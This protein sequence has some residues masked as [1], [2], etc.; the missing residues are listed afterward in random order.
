MEKEVGPNWVPLMGRFE[1]DGD[2]LVFK[3]EPIDAP[4]SG[5]EKPMVGLCLS[6]QTFGE[7]RISSEIEFRST[8]S[9][10]V[11]EIVFFYDPSTRN[12]LT[13]GLSSLAA[14]MFGIRHWNSQIWTQIAVSGESS[15]LKSGQSY[16]IQLDTKGSRASLTVDGVEVLTATLP[17]PPPESQVGVFCL[18]ASETRIRRFE[19]QRQKPR[20]FV[21]MQFTPQYDELYSEVIKPVCDDLGIVPQRADETSTP[22]I[23]VADIA[24]QII[25]SK[26][27]IAE[28]SPAN[29]NVYY[30]V[31]FSHALNKPTILIADKGTRPPFDVAPF[32][33]LFY[34]NSIGGKKKVEDGLRQYLKSI[35]TTRTAGQRLVA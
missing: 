12:M 19:I 31:G 18:G 5:E 30:E 9:G 17:F 35:L 7:G 11:S 33:I 3:G 10:V 1:H 13:A 22:G 20:A 32:R 4:G 34:E 8:P 24:R 29:P 27:V 6:N 2:D 28:V 25:E 15:N 23:V 26:V 16:H 14:P 21:V